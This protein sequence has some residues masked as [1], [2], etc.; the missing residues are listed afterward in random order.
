[1]FRIF[2]IAQYP[3][4]AGEPGSTAI[5]RDSSILINWA[6]TCSLEVGF[7]NLADTSFFYAGSN[8]ANYGTSVDA[9][10]KSD[11]H[12]VTLGD[13]GSALLS[14]DPPITNGVGFDFA[15]FEN[16]LNDNFLEL[17]FVEVSSDSVRF[18][19][20]PSVSLTP[21]KPQVPTFGKIFATKI[22][23][24]AG[25]YRVF[26]GTPFDLDE[27]KDSIGLDILHIRYVRVIDVGGCIDSL[28][29]SHDSQGHR[30]NDPWP[31]PFNTGGF[32]LDAI[33]V[34]NES[35]Q[36]VKEN[37]PPTV[38]LFPNPAEQNIHVVI[39]R[40]V[41]VLINI[42][43][44]EGVRVTAIISKKGSIN[45]DLSGFPHGVYLGHF[46]FPDGS[47]EIQKIIKL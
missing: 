8:K 11:D 18:V 38:R 17:A 30:I 19:R 10:S 7:I 12:V 9:L 6:K 15:V 46:T 3:P 26:F 28:F 5:S 36:S 33:G 24:L 35:L 14:F 25:K 42:Y 45:I 4:S 41:T 29:A 32:D 13:A 2:A 22:N 40:E 37:A 39:P 34:I 47:T 1:M 44:I 27:L 31:T 23:N 21:E 20:F 16:G 43:T